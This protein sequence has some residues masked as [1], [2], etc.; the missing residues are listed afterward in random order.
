MLVL[1]AVTAGAFESPMVAE[2]GAPSAPREV[3]TSHTRLAALWAGETAFPE[4]ELLALVN[5]TDPIARQFA[6]LRLSELEPLTEPALGAPDPG[7]GEKDDSVRFQALAGLMRLGRPATRVLAEVLADREEIASFSYDFEKMHR[8]Q[9]LTISRSDL[10]FAA[11]IHARQW[12]SMRCWTPIKPLANMAQPES[13]LRL[14]WLK[15]ASGRP[16]RGRQQ[17]ASV[18]APPT[19]S[20]AHPYGTRPGTCGGLHPAFMTSCKVTMSPSKSPLQK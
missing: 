1:W 4:A 8:K 16:S 17:S 15:R 12:M 13:Q 3:A 10:A 9:S 19:P 11:L 6:V 5:D 7:P 20:G 14:R 18:S 2:G